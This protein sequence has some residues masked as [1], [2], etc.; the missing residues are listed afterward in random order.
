VCSQAGNDIFGD[1]GISVA[2][3]GNISYMNLQAV[4]GNEY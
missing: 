4:G 3:G 1:F 2:S